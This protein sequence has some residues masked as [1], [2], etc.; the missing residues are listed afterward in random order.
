V[1]A[2]QFAEAL[3]AVLNVYTSQVTITAVA[4]APGRRHLLSGV[5]V[6]SAIY[7]PTFAGAQAGSNALHARNLLT[8]AQLNAAG[9]TACSGFTLTRRSA[10]VPYNP[11]TPLVD[12]GSLLPSTVAEAVPSPPPPAPPPPPPL[13]VRVEAAAMPI[14]AAAI[15]GAA[16][17]VSAAV[18]LSA[19][20]IACGRKQRR[21]FIAQGYAAPP[22]AGV[23]S[24]DP[25]SEK[26]A[27][28]QQRR[29]NAL[30][31]LADPDCVGVQRRE[32][33]SSLLQMEIFEDVTSRSKSMSAWS[34]CGTA[35]AI[36]LSLLRSAC[37]PAC[38]V[39]RLV[40]RIPAQQLENTAGG[41]DPLAAVP[42]ERRRDALQR[43]ADPECSGTTRREALVSL[44]QSEVSEI[45]SSR[46][47]AAPRADAATP[48]TRQAD[49]VLA[50]NMA[51]AA[52][53]TT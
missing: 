2:A 53:T 3:A 48:A 37:T 44:L 52:S 28:F 25:L 47:K 8:V 18:L 41:D 7:M 49:E 45:A 43:L 27:G 26:S 33:L 51:P 50:A 20:V 4:N 35:I 19:C 15:G 39:R 6:S 21:E 46:T 42:D 40:R 9:L 13:P 1:Q 34:I 12:V 17:G 32:T 14:S 22:P 23:A 16:A 24:D 29:H 31:L 36:A 10:M 38:C 30:L 5:A 11:A